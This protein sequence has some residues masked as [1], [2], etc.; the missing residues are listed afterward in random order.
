MHGSMS[1]TRR[2]ALEIL[3]RDC[4]ADPIFVTAVPDMKTYGD[5]AEEIALGT[6]V[7][8]AECPTHSIYYDD[9]ILGPYPK[10]HKQK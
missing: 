7:W 5:Y 10:Y 6:V 9:R 3:L 4:P 1:P 8:V 2:M